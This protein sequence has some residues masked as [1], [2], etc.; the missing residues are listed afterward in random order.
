MCF[1]RLTKLRCRHYESYQLDKTGCKYGLGRQC[2]E[3]KQLQ[4]REE[5]HRSC[6][7][8]KANMMATFGIASH[9]LRWAK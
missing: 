4:V 3:Y 9:S 5:T 2:P 6:V 8:C 1:E 7:R